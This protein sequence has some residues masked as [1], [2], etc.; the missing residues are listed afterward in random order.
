VL[1]EEPHL[2]RVFGSS[3]E[4]YLRNVPRWIPTWRS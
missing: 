3:Y 2:R 1:Y 4:D